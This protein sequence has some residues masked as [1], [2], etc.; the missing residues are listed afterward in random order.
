M[1]EPRI[2]LRADASPLMACLAQ[3]EA[4][5]AQP[6]LLPEIRED[7]VGLFQTPEQAFTLQVDRLAAAAADEL[8]VRLDP[9]DRLLGLMLAGGARNAQ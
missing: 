9:S 1:P 2:T 5:L 6:E 4:L 7:L 8:V 3:A